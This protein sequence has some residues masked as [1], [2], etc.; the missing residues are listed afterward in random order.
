[1]DINA[2]KRKGGIWKD[3]LCFVPSTIIETGEFISGGK[4]KK[5]KSIQINT[6]AF[7][8]GQQVCWEDPDFGAYEG[9]KFQDFKFKIDSF[10]IYDKHVDIV[11]DKVQAFNQ[12]TGMWE[13][14]IGLGRIPLEDINEFAKLKRK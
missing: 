13:K 1:M 12:E 6:T 14:D 10:L 3:K 7:K 4:W 2:C 9:D 11:P 5:T 8:K